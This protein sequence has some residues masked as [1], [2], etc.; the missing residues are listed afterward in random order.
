VSV[1]LESAAG[2]VTDVHSEQVV[3]VA[4]TTL[5]TPTVGGD[6]LLRRV[7]SGVA[8]E[9]LP[10]PERAVERLDEQHLDAPDAR[11][12]RRRAGN[13]VSVGDDE[14]AGRNSEGDHARKRLGRLA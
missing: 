3:G 1:V 2:I 4:P 5:T 13:T 10:P 9:G 11:C 12:S 14:V 6:Q 7:A 8:H